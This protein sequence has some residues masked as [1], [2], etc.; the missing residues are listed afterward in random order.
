MDNFSQ[1]D[2]SMEYLIIGTVSGPCMF[3]NLTVWTALVKG[4]CQSNDWEYARAMDG[5]YKD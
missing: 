4:T 1:R 5:L 2:M 3:S